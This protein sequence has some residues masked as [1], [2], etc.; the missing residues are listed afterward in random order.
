MRKWIK[1]IALSVSVAIIGVALLTPC[2]YA[3]SA[4]VSEDEKTISKR[5][6]TNTDVVY[7]DDGEGTT[8]PV[9]ITE[10]IYYNNSNQGM[11]KSMS[12]TAKVGETRSY[13]VK[14]SNEAMGIP[15]VAGGAL[16]LAAKKK[17][18]KILKNAIVKKLG[19]NFLP[20]VNFIS[21]ALSAAALANAL[22]GK[23]GIAIT[24]GLK[25]KRTYIHKEGYYV[26]GWSPTSL[27]VK[28]Y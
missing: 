19:S 21:W 8:V 16:T 4:D 17:A 9:E 23:N 26:Y 12:P 15:S 6:F 28:R 20:G 10:T 5:V 13:T 1:T 7:V 22:T 24:V 27:S 11:L 3:F 25:Y 2:T 18:V 14:I